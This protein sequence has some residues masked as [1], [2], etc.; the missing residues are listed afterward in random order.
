MINEYSLLTHSVFT[1]VTIN[2]IDVNDKTPEIRLPITTTSLLENSIAMSL[3]TNEIQGRDPDSSASLKF[4]INWDETYATKSGQPTDKNNFIDCFIIQTHKT[5]RINLVV[6]Q[7]L[8]NPSFA[9]LKEVDYEQFDTIFLAIKIIDYNQE[10]NSNS[11]QQ[12]L[13]LRIL[14]VNDNAPEFV[15]NTLDEIR[16]VVE[17]ASVG[18]LVGTILAID[19]DG[20]GN[21][22][23][24]YNLK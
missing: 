14:D 2:V 19:I 3:V 21:N 24:S 20:I 7:L 23:I 11:S 15:E 13:T 9:A 5:D 16:H 6:G 17:E 4:T 22:E 12:M 18:T 8:V 1:Q 10:I